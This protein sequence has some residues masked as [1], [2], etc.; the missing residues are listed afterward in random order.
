MGEAQLQQALVELGFIGE[1]IDDTSG[2]HYA[3]GERFLDLLTFLGCSPVINLSAED[4]D[5]YCFIELLSYEQPTFLHGSQSF[6]PRCR[7]CREPI[8]NWRDQ[9]QASSPITCPSCGQAM[10]LSEVNWKQ[11][12]GYASQFVV[13]HNIYLHEAVPGEKL[14]TRLEGLTE[15]KPWTYFYAL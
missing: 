3:A 7:H 10:S 13:V 15:S 8:P 11:S 1:A 4:G 5:A 12:A 6:Q 9:I 2:H 14:M